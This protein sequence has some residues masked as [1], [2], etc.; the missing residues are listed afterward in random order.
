MA[1]VLLIFALIAWSVLG[2]AAVC[3]INEKRIIDFD[4]MKLWALVLFAL[5]FGPI[6]WLVFAVGALQVQW[7]NSWKDWFEKTCY[8]KDD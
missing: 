8:R 5:P 7:E 1:I 4:R 3:T 6:A 2:V